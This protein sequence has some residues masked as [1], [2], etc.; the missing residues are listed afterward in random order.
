M[1]E[2]N[3]Q[4]IVEIDP[5]TVNMAIEKMRAEIMQP[6]EIYISCLELKPDQILVVYCPEDWF[7]DVSSLDDWVNQL[8]TIL[9]QDVNWYFLIRSNWVLLIVRTHPAVVD[10]ESLLYP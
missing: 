1:A 8:Q 4:M 2:L 5:D 7:D 3:S 6:L 9:P 10:H